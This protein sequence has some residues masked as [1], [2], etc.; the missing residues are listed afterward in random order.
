MGQYLALQN[1]MSYAKEEIESWG[2]TSQVQLRQWGKEFQDKLKES[3]RQG[4]A[5][6]TST[7][8]FYRLKSSYVKNGMNGLRM[9]L[10]YRLKTFV[11]QRGLS[12]FAVYAQMKASD[13]RYPLEWFPLT[14]SMQRKIHLHVGPTNSGKTYQALQRLEAAE[15]GIYAGPL[16]LLAHEVYTRLN[17]K[18]KLCALITG[19]ERRI[20]EGLDAVMSSCTVEMVNL[21]VKVDVAVI[22]EIQMMGHKERGWAWT[23]A[24]LGIRA[25]E[26]HLCGEER[27]VPLIQDLCAAMGDPLEIHRYERL[28][29]LRMMGE[30]LKGDLSKLEKGDAVISFSRVGIHALKN[31]IEAMTGK[32]CAMVYGSLPP[33]TR[34]QQANLFN[35]PENDY[36]ILVATDAIGMGLNLSIKRVI[37]ESTTKNDGSILQPL[38]ISEIKQIAG[39]A[40]RYRTVAQEIEASVNHEDLSGNQPLP[41]QESVGYVTTLNEFDFPRVKRAMSRNTSPITSAGILPPSEVI[42]RFAAYFPPVTPFSY[43]MHR[44]SEVCKT[45][46][47]FHMCDID[48]KLAVADAIQP[49]NLTIFDRIKFI[50]APIALRDRGM[51]HATRLFA[52]CVSEQSGGELLEMEGV[53]LEILD[54][55]AGTTSEYLNRLEALHKVLTNYLWLSYRFAGVFKSQALC[56]HVKSLVE[57]KIKDYLSGIKEV[58]KKK[59][60]RKRMDKIYQELDSEDESKEDIGWEEGEGL[61]ETPREQRVPL[62]VSC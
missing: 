2:I 37:F 17:A 60:D 51:Y 12:K 19:E 18:G 16:R 23:Q 8:L 14:R 26:L 47:R 59:Y 5:R 36:D 7:E 20:P 40:G 27:T 57:D 45:H 44:F 55:P 43:I 42:A 52:K 9:E 13:I 49:Y 30:S 62:V 24:L 61:R 35:D 29:P 48:Q 54:E 38:R 50:K 33:E 1:E 21:S 22:D 28:S 46:P 31:R 11:L 39:R 10:K 15:T 41:A 4:V 25:K 56:F 34:A 53:D 3:C 58:A 6:E 32:Q